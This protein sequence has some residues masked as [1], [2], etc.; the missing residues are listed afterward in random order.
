[1]CLVSS[2]L[3]SLVIS[4]RCVV[5]WSLWRIITLGVLSRVSASNLRSRQC[6]LQCGQSRCARNGRVCNSDMKISVKSCSLSW[7]RFFCP[8]LFRVMSHRLVTVLVTDGD[9][10]SLQTALWHGKPSVVVPTSPDQV[11]FER[12][13]LL[14]RFSFCLCC[15]TH[16]ASEY[17]Q[18]PVCVFRV[19][20]RN[21]IEAVCDGWL[22]EPTVLFSSFPPP[23][24]PFGC[25]VS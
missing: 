8:F 13:T 22:G 21:R 1:M 19:E 2:R 24:L 3:V 25:V 10:R 18:Y 15:C 16:I 4:G 14:G 5:A 6:F 20:N 17:V 23:L 11:R 12:R 7:V 9:V